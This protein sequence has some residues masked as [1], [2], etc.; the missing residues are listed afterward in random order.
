MYDYKAIECMTIKPVNVWLYN[1]WM[2]DYK[3]SECMTIK[4]VNVWL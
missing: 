4:P 3:A 2:Y 1:Q